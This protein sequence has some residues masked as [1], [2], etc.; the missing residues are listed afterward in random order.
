MIHSDLFVFIINWLLFSTAYFC[1]NFCNQKA[2]TNRLVWHLN[3]AQTE[4]FEKELFDPLTMCKQM[5]DV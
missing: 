5:T 3:C 2:V 1:R 4:L